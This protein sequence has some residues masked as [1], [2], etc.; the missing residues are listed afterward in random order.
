M[1]RILLSAAATF[2]LTVVS[3]QVMADSALTVLGQDFEF[4]NKI[5]GLPAKLCGI[6]GD[7]LFCSR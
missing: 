1:N 6:N 5:D 7:P 2:I 3:P 4:P